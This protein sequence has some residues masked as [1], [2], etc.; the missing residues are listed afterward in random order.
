MTYAE[1]LGRESVIAFAKAIKQGIVSNDE[2]LVAE[3]LLAL[4]ESAITVAMQAQR[5]ACARNFLAQQH[6]HNA[7]WFIANEEQHGLTLNAYKQAILNAEV[8]P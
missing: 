6:V 4:L 8:Q 3:N 7:I 1:K 5:E 2:N